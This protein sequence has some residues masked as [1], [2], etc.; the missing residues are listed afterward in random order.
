MSI[1][2]PETLFAGIAATASDWLEPG[3]K[4]SDEAGASFCNLEVHEDERQPFR[5]EDVSPWA[6][7]NIGGPAARGGSR[8]EDECLLVGSAAGNVSGRE[9][10]FHFV[11]QELEGDVTITAQVSRLGSSG[12]GERFGVMLRDSLEPDAA[13]ASTLFYSRSLRLI[14]RLFAGNRTRSGNRGLSQAPETWVRIERRGDLF[15]GSSSPDG[16]TWTEIHRVTFDLPETLF[17]GIA[18]TVGSGDGALFWSDEA[19]AKFCNVEVREPE[20]FL[21]G[22]CNAD[23]KVDIADGVSTLNLL[24][25]GAATPLCADAADT[26]D[27][28]A[29]D[30]SDG[31]AIFNHLFTDGAAPPMP[32]PWV[33][34][35]DPTRD[36]LGCGEFAACR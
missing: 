24:F 13:H 27:S 15:I 20:P 33:C 36:E 29:L 16:T 18:A 8:F 17:G 4:R 35:P 26:D 23:G 28:G 22:D 14:Y 21:R 30:I 32:G 5:S 7:V 10:W 6:S 2:L 3:G 25:L 11:Y 34:G 19:V 1:H 9:D 31:L 12:P